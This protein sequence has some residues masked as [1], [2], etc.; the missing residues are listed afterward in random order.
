MLR[1]L[2]KK[3]R[4]QIKRIHPALLA[5]LHHDFSRHLRV[6]RTV[7]V[8]RTRFCEGKRETVFR[9]ESL[10]FEHL[11]VIAG[12]DMRNIVVVRPCDRGPGGNGNVCRAKAEV[13]DLDCGATYEFVARAHSQARLGSTGT[14][15]G[16]HHHCRQSEYPLDSFHLF[17]P[18]KSL[19]KL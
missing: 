14:S 13:V 10:R 1:M 3:R 5:S 6:D 15:K 7:V 2:G 8:V 4:L 17:S 16:C 12:D 9:I 19:L 18:L 11:V